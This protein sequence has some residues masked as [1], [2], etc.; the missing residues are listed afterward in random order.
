MSSNETMKDS[1]IVWI[2]KIP[3]NWQLIKLKYVTKLR[4]ESGYCDENLKYI[5]LEN[6]E[7]STGRYIETDLVVQG[8]CSKFRSGDVL[9]SKLRPY[10]EKVT[11]LKFDGFCT[12]E[13]LVF[14]EYKGNFHYL[15]Y[16]LLSPGFIN[17]VNSST[18][19]VKMPRAEWDY[20][21][22]LKIPKIGVLEQDKIVK[23]IDFKIV[24][25]ENI[26]DKIKLQ[27]EILEKYRKSLICEV[28]TKGLDETV[29][30]KD[31][32]V[33]WIGKIPHHWKLIKCGY[34]SKVYSGDSIENTNIQDGEYF[35]YG[36]GKSLGKYDSYNVTKNQL[37]IGR[38]GANCGCIARLEENAWATDN[39]L[40][41]NPNKSFVNSSYLYYILTAKDLNN[42]KDVNAQ[43][44]ITS[45]KVLNLLIPLCY[46]MV[47]QKKI[48]DYLDEKLKIIDSL[49]NYKISQMDI[50]EKYKKSVIYEYVSGKK[51]IFEGLE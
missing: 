11:I 16:Y 44:L 36:G 41:V 13:L 26:V 34:V 35:V 21:K 32:G 20:I 25:I 46:D 8:K 2:G 5:G 28:V 7:S 9:F 27:I 37:L 45:S 30:M 40:I 19:G 4:L 51:R 33:D 24:Q 22:N 3:C 50:L 42:L 10:L 18:Y 39:A 14:K 48:V 1:G 23:F 17:V 38:V 12:G 49:I 29:P 47:E 6:I 31:S 15:Y 43:P